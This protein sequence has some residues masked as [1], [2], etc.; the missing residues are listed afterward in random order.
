MIDP[1]NH[2]DA[3]GPFSLLEMVDHH[4]VSLKRRKRKEVGEWS[5]VER[6]GLRTGRV[7]GDNQ[8]QHLLVSFSPP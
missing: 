6:G 3:L 4:R 7:G 2:N 8:P 1:F 5:V